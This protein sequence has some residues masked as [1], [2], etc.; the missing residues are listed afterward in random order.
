MHEV[1]RQCDLKLHAHFKG[2]TLQQHLSVAFMSVL[3]IVAKCFKLEM[4]FNLTLWHY[5]FFKLVPHANLKMFTLNQIFKLMLVVMF[6]T[7]VLNIHL[8][9]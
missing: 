6:L 9:C 7:H 2:L 5:I 1:K 3:Q 4:Q 8:A